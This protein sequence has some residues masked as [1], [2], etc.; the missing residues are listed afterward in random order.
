M[1]GAGAKPCC[2]ARLKRLIRERL[3]RAYFNKSISR[4]FVSLDRPDNCES[5]FARVGYDR[6]NLSNQGIVMKTLITTV[7]AVTSIVL[8]QAEPAGA[9]GSRTWVASNGDD[10]SAS[11]SFTSP[12]KSIDVAYDKTPRAGR[13]IAGIAWRSGGSP[14]PIRLR[15]TVK[16]ELP[17]TPYR[18]NHRK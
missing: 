12:C 16:E 11:C 1:Q 13:S 8:S 18:H 17:P 5:L 9:N 15:S 7:L 6:F 10:N 2:R 14:S 4:W 3:R